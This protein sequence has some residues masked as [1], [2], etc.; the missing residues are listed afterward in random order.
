[1]LNDVEKNKQV[2]TNASQLW[3][4]FTQSKSGKVFD[5]TLCKKAGM[6][7]HHFEGAGIGKCAEVKICYHDKHMYV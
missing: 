6:I 4:V 3:Q 2:N 1:M 5:G 7:A